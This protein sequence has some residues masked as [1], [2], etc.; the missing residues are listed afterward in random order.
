M[1]VFNQGDNN[2]GTQTESFL[3]KLVATKGEQ[4]RDPEAVAKGYLNSQEMINHL[5]NQVAEMQEDL[6]KQ[7]YAKALLERMGTQGQAPSTPTPT[8]ITTG[9]STEAPTR[10]VESD[11]IK[12]LINEAITQRERDATAKQNLQS[13]EA[14]LTELFGDTA[15]KVVQDK[16]ASLGMSMERLQEIA[17]ESPTAFLQLIGEPQRETPRIVTQG[18]INTSRDSFTSTSHERDWNYYQNLRRTNRKEYYS[19]KVQNQML[20]DKLRLG[21]RFGNT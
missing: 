21:D 9:T 15:S 1:T 7:D 4:W 12:S 6:T 20:Q 13:A 14:K 10:A 11:E 19:P 3:D 5:K 2:Q 18:S 16:A 17:Q 8:P